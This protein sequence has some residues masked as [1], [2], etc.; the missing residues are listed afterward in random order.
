M[1]MKIGQRYRCL[2][3]DCCCEIEVT[4]AS[5]EANTNPRCCCGAENPVVTR[6]AERIHA[7]TGSSG[8]FAPFCPLAFLLSPDQS[9]RW[10]VGAVGIEPPPKL[11]DVATQTHCF[12]FVGFW[13]S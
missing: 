9:G 8:L 13:R 11:G 2:N 12:S 3:P 1:T 4:R 5:T 7:R 6:A 10:L